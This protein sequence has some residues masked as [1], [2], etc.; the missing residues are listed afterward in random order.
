MGVEGRFSSLRGRKARGVLTIDWSP[1]EDGQFLDSFEA[2]TRVTCTI[3]GI[4]CFPFREYQE[5]SMFEYMGKVYPSVNMESP[6][7][8]YW[9][10]MSIY[11]SDFGESNVGMYGAYE[12][13]FELI[14]LRTI[15]R[16]DQQPTP[17]PLPGSLFL[18]LGIVPVGMFLRSMR[19]SPKGL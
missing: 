16:P 9:D 11:G 3:G 7:W 12:A 8:Y 17:V 18:A 19:R 14:S 15:S 6:A 1:L 2:N 10:F 13:Y 4:K 5:V